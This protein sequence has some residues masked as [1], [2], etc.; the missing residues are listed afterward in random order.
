[1]R[2][3][4]LYVH[5]NKNSLRDSRCVTW[6]VSLTTLSRSTKPWSSGQYCMEVE[7]KKGFGICSQLSFISPSFKNISDDNYW[8]LFFRCTLNIWPSVHPSSPRLRAASVGCMSAVSTMIDMLI[9][10]KVVLIKN[11]YTFFTHPFLQTLNN[12]SLFSLV[13]SYH[14]AYLGRHMQE[15]DKYLIGLKWRNVIL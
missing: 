13:Q 4:L 8:L 2:A 7:K 14:Y 15:Q 3:L 11:V 12:S 5:I 10:Y 9:S 1:M 6:T